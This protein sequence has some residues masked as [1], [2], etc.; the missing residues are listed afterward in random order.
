[1][2]EVTPVSAFDDNY[3]WL[4]GNPGSKRLVAVDPG[5]ETPVL[6]WL[7]QHGASLCGILITHHHYD[8][9]GGV[10]ELL[11]A[12]P[13]IP[14]YGPARESIRGVSH[15]VGEGDGVAIDGLEADLQVLEVP[16]HT[17]GHIAYY[18]EDALFCGDTLFAAGCGRVFDGTF[19][20]LSHSLQ[21]IA[22][23]PGQTRIYCAHE[24]T[25]DNLGFAVWVEPE[26]PSLLS[27][28]SDEERKR[29][30]GVPTLPAL[31]EVELATNPFLRTAV[32]HVKSVA[33]QAAGQALMT[34]TA[35]FTALRQWKDREYD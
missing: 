14:V 17:A 26:S 4:L 7:S 21:R 10:P 19:E 16:G 5:D 1:M 24:Y 8:H 35:V 20:Q 15:P 25:L 23:L 27:R 2:L 9:V 12:F 28:I 32:E 29:E 22:G 11:E 13:G 34:Q 3:I 30:S 6:R 31:L 18:G 33:E